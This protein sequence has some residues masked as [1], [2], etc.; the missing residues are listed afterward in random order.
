MVEPLLSVPFASFRCATDVQPFP[1]VA[2]LL[3]Q[4]AGYETVWQIANRVC[5]KHLHQ[6][7][8]SSMS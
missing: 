5:D 2:L 8:D 7:A 1:G 3:M 4:L 6:L